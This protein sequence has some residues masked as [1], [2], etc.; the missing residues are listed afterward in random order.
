MRRAR[1]AWAA[2]AAGAAAALLL[3]AAL[4][5]AAWAQP[6][7]SVYPVS[8]ALDPAPAGGAA[9]VEP[10]IVPAPDGANAEWV[11]VSGRRQDV[12]SI[13]PGGQ[14]AQVA[15]G[16]ATGVGV[17]ATYASVDAM[18]YDWILDN[19]QGPGNVLY[20]VGAADSASPGINQVARFGDYGQDM[21]LGPDGAL[22]VADNQGIIRCQ[23]TAAP[24]AVCSTAAVPPP[25]YT[26]AGAFAIGSGGG[27][28]WFTDGL[29]EIGAYTSSG[30]SGPY[31]AAGVAE[32]SA[33]PGTIVTAPDGEVY[34]AGGAGTGGG[35]NSEILAF[36]PADPGVVRVAASGL[37]NVVA[38][39]IGP[40]GNVW[41]L[42]DSGSG[43]VGQLNTGSG[44]VERYA[45]PSGSA[46]PAGGWRIADGPA[47]P[48]A[49]G[50][51]E[52]FFT[53]AAATAGGQ[54]AA[55]V[56]VVSGIP[57]PVAPGAL[58]FKREISVSRRRVAVMTLTCS[59]QSNALCEGRL[60]LSATA[61]VASSGGAR[62]ARRHAGLHRRLR[63]QLMRV[64]LGRISYDVRGGRFARAVL[65]L[66]ARAYQLLE[67]AARRRLAVTVASLPRLGTVSGRAVAL[68]GP[69]PGRA[70]ARRHG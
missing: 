2:R 64:A 1:A 28:V 34:V 19:D 59:G 70:P 32:A 15:G 7:V 3:T 9:V 24:S 46:L 17:P 8:S 26:G 50:E 6:V 14:Q 65:R 22:Y 49:A 52:V 45:L 69:P 55:A 5:A 36:S 68:T 13:A 10:A 29:G 12:I 31:P 66:S 67:H 47:V 57:F 43:Y 54:P 11:V 37:G 56:G 39:A 23:I 35:A 38:M 33:D 48:N 21:T 20:A 58:A 30:F 51:G 63:P 40:D 4:P 62:I 25:F 41:F 42:S 44:A 27:A 18:G 16:L 61:A 53:A 60:T